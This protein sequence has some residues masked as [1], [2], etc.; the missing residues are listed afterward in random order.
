MNFCS[1]SIKHQRQAQLGANS[2]IYG[3]SGDLFEG[4]CWK[5]LVL[6]WGLIRGG[7]F[8]EEGGAIRGF[9]V[10]IILSSLIEASRSCL[11]FPQ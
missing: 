9:T 4:A 8:F 2:E 10:Y 3:S 11:L 6:E 5:F 7:G 1:N